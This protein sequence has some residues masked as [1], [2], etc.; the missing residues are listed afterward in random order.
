CYYCHRPGH[1]AIDCKKKKA[2]RSSGAARGAGPSNGRTVMSL[3][4]AVAGEQ[5]MQEHG[6]DEWIGDSGSTR[7]VTSSKDGM[8]DYVPTQEQITLGDGSRITAEG[9]GSLIVRVQMCAGGSQLIELHKVLYCPALKANLFS[10]GQAQETGD[11]RIVLEGDQVIVQSKQSPEFS[12]AG[13]R[14][15]GGGRLFLFK[16]E[17]M[18]KDLSVRANSASVGEKQD[19]NVFHQRMGHLS[20]DYT[21][22]AAKEWGI[23]LTGGRLRPCEGCAYGKGQQKA[24]PK[25]TETRATRKLERVLVDTAPMSSRSLGGSRNWIMVVDDATRMMWS[26]FREYRNQL[27]EVMEDFFEAAKARGEPVKYLRADNAGEHQG[28]LQAVCRKHG[29]QLEYTASNTPQQNGVVE[30]AIATVR[31]NAVAMLE[32]SEFTADEKGKL[33]A[34]CIN[35]ATYLVNVGPCA[36]N[37]DH[38]SRWRSFHGER[39]KILQYLRKFGGVGFVTDRQRIKSKMG[40]KAHRCFMV[41][42]AKD[43]AADTYRM[44]NPSTRRVILSRDIRWDEFN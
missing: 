10:L 18:E 13:K 14:Q 12:F 28:R 41:G 31:R 39:P 25:S 17:R 9:E 26:F 7:H 5:L 35:T 15:A 16:M 44:Y 30:R 8:L 43:H 42:Y 20:E 23:T 19:I 3:M 33:W 1:K 21:R 34:E 2:D 40:R 29:V 36:S 6:E 22:A 4:A 37:S 11:T 24:V 38:S 27:A 32:A